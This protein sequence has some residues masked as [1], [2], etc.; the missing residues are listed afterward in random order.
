MAPSRVSVQWLSCERH[1]RGHSSVS[2]Q[3]PTRTTTLTRRVRAATRAAWWG[4]RT[5]NVLARPRR[6]ALLFPFVSV[7]IFAALFALPT[8]VREVWTSLR[9]AD[10]PV[11]DTIPLKRETVS[12]QRAVL[13]ADSSLD[14]A[15][16]RYLEAQAETSTVVHATRSPR[17]DSLRAL[18]RTLEALVARAADAPLP[19]SYRAIAESPAM[20]GDARA[21]ALLDSLSDI[22]RE[23]DEFGAGAA[24]DP[25]FVSLTTRGNALGRAIVATAGETRE[26]LKR[27]LATIDQPRTP[28]PVAAVTLPDTL[29]AALHRD[30]AQALLKTAQRALID[31][32]LANISARS[33][34]TEARKATQLAPVP[35]LVAGSIV[36]AVTLIF[37]LSLGEEIRAPRV[38][39]HYEA[40]QIVT[41]RVLSVAGVRVIPEQRMRRAA[42]RQRPPLLDPQLDAYRMLAWHVS[43]NPARNGVLVVTGEAP[44]V[45]AV[46]AANIAAVL[47]NEARSVLLLDVDFDRGPIADILHVPIA[48]GLAAVLENRR[49]WS[50]TI[51][52]VT[53][54]R[55]RT[56]DCIPA[57]I[58][59]RSLGPAEQEALRNEIHRAGRRYDATVVYAPPSAAR[60]ALAGCD[61]LICATVSRTRIR[62]L[63]KLAAGLRKDTARVLGVALWQG[64]DLRLRTG[65]G[66]RS[67]T[68][69]WVK[70]NP[71]AA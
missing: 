46:I 8:G 57:G 25:V 48:P 26:G 33:A 43:A 19:E 42:D 10:L 34:A 5:R 12:A 55:G 17:A 40:E 62:M 63:A 37:A 56:L 24:V 31:A 41:A 69:D 44:L 71:D 20:R 60:G 27:E 65:F 2:M 4:A 3:T 16:R 66:R 38:A 59:K 52:Q 51:V 58:R 45:T 6:L 54:G 70:R 30:S 53:A 32:K 50:E 14:E 35:V 39:D 21:K 28:I 9:V 68:S 22:E 61:A 29:G 64:D 7:A 13:D 18:I 23:R 49:R 15:R 1:P 67:P 36:L 47:A 11:R